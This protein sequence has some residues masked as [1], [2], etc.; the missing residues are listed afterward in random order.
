ME[1]I[2]DPTEDI[3]FKN[4]FGKQGNEDLLEDLVG[5]IIGRKIKTLTVMR[6]ARVGRT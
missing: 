3:V 6:E 5:N 4:L 1:S 2:L